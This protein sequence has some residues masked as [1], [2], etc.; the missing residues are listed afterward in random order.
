MAVSYQ[1]QAMRSISALDPIGRCLQE[2]ERYDELASLNDAVCHCYRTLR[3]SYCIIEYDDIIRSKLSPSMSR[4]CINDY[5]S[6]T[7]AGVGLMLSSAGYSLREI[8]AD[9][10]ITLEFDQQRLT[11][12][13]FLLISSACEC[14]PSEAEITVSLKRNGSNAVITI[15][16]NGDGFNMEALNTL[17]S[18][19][20]DIDFTSQVAALKVAKAL[21]ESMG[22]GI[23]LSSRENGGST[24]SIS[25]GIT[26][27]DTLFVEFRSPVKPYLSNRFSDMHVIFSNVC[28]ITMY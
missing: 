12:A 3:M 2:L 13:L 18:N 7:L 8:E 17:F 1:N 22:G 6:S 15:V 26:E 27:P 25:L 4:Y 24:I 16:D 10:R 9:E 28:S 21:I 20:T 19:P 23:I 14:S 5:L 11:R